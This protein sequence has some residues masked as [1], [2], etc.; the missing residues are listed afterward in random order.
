MTDNFSEHQKGLIAPLTKFYDVTPDDDN[1]L[2]VKPRAVLVG[3]SGDLEIIDE[4]GTTIV[5]HDLAAGLWPPI[6]PARIK[7]G[8]TTASN[9]IAAD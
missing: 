7:S 1:D 2:S 6:R 4:A 5:I 8:N 3:T 9:I